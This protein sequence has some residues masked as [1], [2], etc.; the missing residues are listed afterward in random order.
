[1][2]RLMMELSVPSHSRAREFVRS[3]LVEEC[4]HD[5]QYLAF[6]IFNNGT[7]KYDNQC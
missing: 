5:A 4:E 2:H 1:M 6:S 7:C 3:D